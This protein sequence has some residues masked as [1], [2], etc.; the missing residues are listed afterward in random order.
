LPYV[1]ASRDPGA[2]NNQGGLPYQPYHTPVSRIYQWTVSVQ[3]QFG[4]FM[5]EAAYVGSHANGLQFQAD[6]N[7]VPAA[8]LGQ[9][10]NARPYPQ[11]KAIGPAYSGSLIGSFNNISNY[12][13]MQLSVRKRLGHGLT[14]EANY[15]WSKMLDDQDT[16]GWGS[17]YGVAVYQNAYTPGTNYGLSNFDTPQAFKGFL[18]Y[19]APLGKG[20]SYLNHGIGDAV[21]GGWELSGEFVAQSGA[22]FTAYMSS[23]TNAGALDGFWYPNLV[24]NPNVANRSINQWFNQLAFAT[25]QNNTFGNVGRNT[26]RGPDLTS[27]DFSLAK[28]FRVARFERAGLQIRMDATNFVNHPSFNAP[29]SKLNAAALASGVPD[30]TVGAITGVSVPGRVIQLATRFS[31]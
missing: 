10:Q 14:G 9:G 12:D 22:P 28:T 25:P 18:V 26:L 11:Y 30:P 21:L 3:R 16:S 20:H 24:G 7:Q 5:T 8:L 19:T 1:L 4:G 29:N 13:S 17:H 27:V 6:I 23:S 2:Y 31:F 15:T